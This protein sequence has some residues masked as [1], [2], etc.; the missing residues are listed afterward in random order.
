MS[1]SSHVYGWVCFGG[2]VPKIPDEVIAKLEHQIESINQDGGL[3]TRFQ[4]GQMVHVVSTTLQGLAEVVE[5]AKSPQH[6]VRVLLEFMGSMVSAQVP[7]ENL[8][9]TG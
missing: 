4:P 6:R 1:R 9:L 3:W 2:I 7:W 8:R 5:E